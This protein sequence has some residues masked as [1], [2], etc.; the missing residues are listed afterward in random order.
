MSVKE[1][2]PEKGMYFEAT[3][4]Q[5]DKSAAKALALNKQVSVRNKHIDLKYHFVKAVMK[6]KIII[7]KDMKSADNTADML[8]K[9]LDLPTTLH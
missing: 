4:V 7:L 3:T 2:W 6:S 1:I 9:V 8:T 5:I